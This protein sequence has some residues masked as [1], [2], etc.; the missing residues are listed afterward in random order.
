MWPC[1]PVEGARR[2]VLHAAVITCISTC[3]T[4]GVR[5]TWKSVLVHPRLCPPTSFSERSKGSSCFAARCPSVHEVAQ[6]LEVWRPPN[7]RC[8]TGSISVDNRESF[9]GRQS[10][11]MRAHMSRRRTR[12]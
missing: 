7:P 6:R 12:A 8:K 10:N 2:V 11:V 3:S 1:A 4:K 5:D 9:V